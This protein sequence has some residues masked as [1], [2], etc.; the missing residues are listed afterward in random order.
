[1]FVIIGERY[2]AAIL[3][4]QTFEHEPMG[5]HSTTINETWHT[6][7]AAVRH[8]SFHKWVPTFH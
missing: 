7:T 5:P 6:L 2:K 3:M 8:A 1:M 4:G